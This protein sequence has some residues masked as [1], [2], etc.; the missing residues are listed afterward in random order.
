MKVLPIN[1]CCDAGK[2]IGFVPVPDDKVNGAGCDVQLLPDLT[3]PV[4]V[5]T[6]NLM[7]RRKYGD[8]NLGEIMPYVAVKS[9]DTPIE[10]LRTIPGFIE[11]EKMMCDDCNTRVVVNATQVAK[12]AP[13]AIEAGRLKPNQLALTDAQVDFLRRIGV[14]E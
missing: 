9:M 13:E 1:C 7:K 10:K 6:P 5:V 12:Y 8:L 4:S 2:L 3:L 11:N 14:V